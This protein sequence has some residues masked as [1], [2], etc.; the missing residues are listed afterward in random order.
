MKIK[1][2][3]LEG[4]ELPYTAWFSNHD[5]LE[6][7]DML[8]NVNSFGYGN[9]AKEAIKDL[10]SKHDDVKFCGAIEC[11]GFEEEELM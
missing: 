1:I 8:N 7:L 11:Y 5:W 9:S 4:I 6:F 2:T 3:K 10:K